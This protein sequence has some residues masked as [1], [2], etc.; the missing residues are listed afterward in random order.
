MRAVVEHRV[1]ASLIRPPVP[2]DAPVRLDTLFHEPRVA[3][4][5]KG[6][7]LA[8][9]SE[10]TIGELD[11]EVFVS[12]DQVEREWLRW[13][14]CDPRP[15]GAPVRYGPVVRTMEESLHV[16]AMGRAVAC[17]AQSVGR[18]HHREDVVFVPVSDVPW[19]PVALCTRLGDRNRLVG[20]LLAGVFTATEA[21]AF[22]A[23]GAVIVAAALMRN[24]RNFGRSLGTA[25]VSTVTSIGQIMF[26]LLGTAIMTRAIALSGLPSLMVEQVNGLGLSRV[27]FL[28]LL[29]VLF[30]AMGAFLDPIAMMLLTVPFLMPVLVAMEI[31]LIWFGVFI[32]HKL[33]QNP[34]VSG[35]TEIRLSHAFIAAAWVL[36]VAIAVLVLLIA[37]PEL[38]SFIGGD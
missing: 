16:V 18:T 22:G 36:P 31:D 26:L 3:V 33:A 8:D 13:W 29:I 23:L 19:C 38:T 10:V 7:R 17:T 2:K 25:L 28:L 24:M 14:S 21:G 32:V 6:H 5:P 27:T 15:S 11:H 30:L 12:D 4:L 37:F 35:K 1:D 20:G 34:V 9:R